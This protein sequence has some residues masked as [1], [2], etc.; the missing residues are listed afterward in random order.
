MLQR[1]A[2]RFVFFLLLLTLGGCQQPVPSVSGG[3]LTIV[4]VEGDDGLITDSLRIESRGGRVAATETETDNFSQ[5]A[6]RV[7]RHVEQ[8]SAAQ[9]RAV[10]VFLQA[11]SRLE[12]TCPQAGS[13]TQELSVSGT[14]Y[15]RTLRGDC[16][17]GNAGYP[18]LRRVLFGEMTAGRVPASRRL[19][20]RSS[21]TFAP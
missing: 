19:D 11:F 15:A 3:P 2:P 8:L 4:Y 16:T 5:P 6:R 12:A 1:T 10:E 13:R 9:L 21:R 20:E 17:W 14:G 7:S 18:A